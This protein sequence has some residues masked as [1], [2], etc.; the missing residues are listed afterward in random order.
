MEDG[1]RE[2]RTERVQQDLEGAEEG[3]LEL[4]HLSPWL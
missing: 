3:V 1:R 2:E 4:G